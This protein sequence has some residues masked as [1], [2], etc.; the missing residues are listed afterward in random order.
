MKYDSDIFRNQYPLVVSF[1][2]HLAYYRAGKPI[3]DRLWIKSP[4]WT[5]TLDAHLKIASIQWCKVFGSDGCNAT[6]WKRTPILDV[7]KAQQSFRDRLKKSC[8]TRD[9]WARRHQAMMNFRNRYVAHSDPN[10]ADPV[11]DFNKALDVAYVYDEWVRDLIRSDIYTGLWLRQ[12]FDEW[13]KAATPIFET[14]MNTTKG[15][16]E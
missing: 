16:K 15:L 11:P 10:N 1:V 9:E 3:Y 12:H 2:Q 7:Q 14:A 13:T 6:H 8:V 5:A 4:L